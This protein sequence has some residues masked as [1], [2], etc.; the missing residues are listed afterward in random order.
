[1]RLDL[2]TG[3]FLVIEWHDTGFKGEAMSCFV[4]HSGDKPEKFYKPWIIF[5]N[6]I[7][8]LYTFMYAL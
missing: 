2:E 7:C 3:I 5:T 6:M 4:R 8:N 1:M